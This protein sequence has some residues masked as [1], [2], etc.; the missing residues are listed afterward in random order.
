MI[1][2]FGKWMV[3]ILTIVWMIII[4]LLSHENATKSTDTSSGVTRFVCEVVL[5]DSYQSMA[6]EEREVLREKVQHIVR[7]CAHMTEYAILGVLL[8]WTAIVHGCKGKKL[9]GA[10]MVGIT[11]SVSD[12]WHQSFIPGRACQSMDVL[13]DSIGVIL[14]VG[15]VVCGRWLISFLTERKDL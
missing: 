6:E 13:I 5:K 9:L 12:E 1:Q 15:I 14:G 10:I 8:T 4:F 3:T 7:K 11:Y 2:Q